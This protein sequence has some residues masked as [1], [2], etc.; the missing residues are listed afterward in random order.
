[1]INASPIS[2]Y[3]CVHAP[4]ALSLLKMPYESLYTEPKTSLQVPR[5]EKRVTTIAQLGYK[6]CVVP[7]T[8]EKA[9]AA[10]NLG[11]LQI[12]GCKNLKEVIDKV[13]TN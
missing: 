8:A 2:T 9:L 4:P 11:D 13:F 10:L 5:I 1:M 6:T 3:L 12:V 7:E